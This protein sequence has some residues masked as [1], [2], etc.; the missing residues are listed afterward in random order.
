MANRTVAHSCTIIREHGC[1]ER[2]HA[3]IASNNGDDPVS[4]ISKKLQGD[5]INRMDAYEPR[6]RGFIDR[7]GRLS[8]L[9]LLIPLKRSPHSAEYSA[10]GVA[11]GMFWALTPL[12]GIQMYLCF[13]TWLLAKQTSG[14]RFSLVIA[15]AW[16]WVSNVFTMLPM[17]Y[18]FYITGQIMIGNWGNISGYETFTRSFDFAFAE[19]VGFWD[20]M[21][22]LTKLLAREVGLA[23]GVGCLP[24]AIIGGWM[25]YRVSLKYIRG[26][27]ARR[28]IRQERRAQKRR[29]AAIVA[30]SP[31]APNS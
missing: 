14:L 11:I 27:R 5:P 15:C 20:S 30:Q 18:G 23:M 22:E 24:Y 6:K 2:W 3:C 7:M 8:R 29:E 19:N 4:N 16:T 12:V 21:V 13:M 1:L 9:K 31:E 25:S 28:L 10:R 26:R 17:Y